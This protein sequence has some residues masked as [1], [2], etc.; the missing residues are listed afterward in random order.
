MSDESVPRF[1]VGS[2]VHPMAG[3]TG[4]VLEVVAI[5]GRWVYG[6]EMPAGNV[7]F[8]VEASLKQSRLF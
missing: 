7:E 2:M 6:I 1:A 4:E 3:T 5:A 8:W